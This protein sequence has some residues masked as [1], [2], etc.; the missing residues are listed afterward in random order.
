MTYKF[1]GVEGPISGGKTTFATELAAVLGPKTLLIL[2]PDEANGGNPWLQDYYAEAER[3]RD[4][5]VP[6][7][8]ASVSYVMQSHLCW[9]R[10]LNHE[11]AALHVLVGEGDSIMDRLLTGDATFA[12]VQ[13]EDGL[14]SP[15]EFAT[16]A[17]LYETFLGE[18]RL[19]SVVLYMKV[20]PEV[21]LA[22]IMRRT[23]RQTGRACE[24][25]IPI[26]YLVRL[27]REIRNMLGTLEKLGTKVIPI[28]WNED[29]DSLEERHDTVVAIAE[30]IRRLKVTNQFFDRHRRIVEGPLGQHVAFAE[31]K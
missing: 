6:R 9:R 23:L 29:R 22:R 8:V 30:E 5:A 10:Y 17:G 11:R 14:M 20:A 26:D 4:P 18:T 24:K 2:E 13:V 1:I 15:K 28:D 31:A 21:C 7:P 12:N 27:D 19:P 3:L 25:V 16:Y